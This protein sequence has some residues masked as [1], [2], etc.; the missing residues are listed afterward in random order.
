MGVGFI[1]AINAEET[2]RALEALRALGEQPYVIGR[3]ESGEK[4]VELAW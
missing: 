2:D 3:C 4:G 1:M